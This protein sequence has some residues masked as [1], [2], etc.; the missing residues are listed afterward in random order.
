MPVQNST[1]I[2]PSPTEVWKNNWVSFSAER[3]NTLLNKRK[4]ELSKNQHA[5]VHLHASDSN[6]QKT[7]KYRIRRVSSFI[8]VLMDSTAPANNQPKRP[9]TWALVLHQF[10][11]TQVYE[12]SSFPVQR[13]KCL[14]WTVFHFVDCINHPSQ[15][16]TSGSKNYSPEKTTEVPCFLP[17]NY[18]NRVPCYDKMKWRFHPYR[19]KLLFPRNHKHRK[20]ERK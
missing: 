17:I 19:L 18:G 16:K 7:Q 4:V 8:R 1:R 14:L 5:R 20:M 2:L 15:K 10:R 13:E 6:S 9:K 3:T 12:S 11:N